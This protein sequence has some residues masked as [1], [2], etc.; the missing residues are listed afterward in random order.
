MVID[1]LPSLNIYSVFFRCVFE[2]YY[3]YQVAEG[4][5]K[6]DTS[7][8]SDENRA[9]EDAAT[10]RN[11]DMVAEPIDNIETTPAEEIKESK[12]ANDLP[13]LNLTKDFEELKSKLTLMDAELVEVYVFF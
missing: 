13:N 11:E 1:V 4:V 7:K 3:A 9:A 6:I 12:P 2:R 8:D 10:I 5:E